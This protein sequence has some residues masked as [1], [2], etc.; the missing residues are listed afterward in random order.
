MRPRASPRKPKRSRAVL[1]F[2]QRT[3]SLKAIP[4]IEFVCGRST[5]RGIEG[6]IRA[7]AIQNKVEFVTREEHAVSLRYEMLDVSGVSPFEG[8]YLTPIDHGMTRGSE[9]KSAATLA[10]EH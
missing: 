6:T 4:Y 8:K 3:S 7:F 1:I 5:M 10:S 2:F 9:R